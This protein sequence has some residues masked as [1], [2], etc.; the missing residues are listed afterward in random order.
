[1]QGV[2]EQIFFLKHYDHWSFSEVYTLPVRLR[3]WFVNRTLKQQKDQQ[4]AH[5]KAR[6]KSS[7]K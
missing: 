7:R 1:M 4:E 2:Y 6:R 3:E 5:E